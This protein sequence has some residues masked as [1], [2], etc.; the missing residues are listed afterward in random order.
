VPD[1]EP[2]ISV[3]I[4]CYEAAETVG[5][6][7]ESALAQST[8]PHEVIVCDD[9]STDE[10]EGSLAPLRDRIRLLRKENG[11]GASA[12]N[13]AAEAATGDFIA[14]LDADDRYEPGRLEALTALAVERPDLE[15]L[16]TDAWLEQEAVR[17]GRYSDINPFPAGDQRAAIFD[18]CF[19][20]GWPA[21]RRRTLLDAGGFDESY[22]IAYDWECW[23]RLIHR[24][25]RVGLVA[26]ALM[27]YRIRGGSL[28]ADTVA[29]LRERLR[30]FEAATHWQLMPHER[31]VLDASIARDRR[32]LAYEELA[33]A[34]KRGSRRDLFKLAFRAH[35][36]LRARATA[37]RAGLRRP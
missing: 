14:I 35:V 20:G 13:R 1:S 15:L 4:P 18:T 6:A 17:I 22:R 23:A 2:T 11:G 31:R 36:P 9:G 30:L 25:A 21:V 26:E 12:L 32:R 33:A 27:T 37:V 19:P 5:E 16:M 3:V 24:G 8:P 34:A 28:S 10:P 29:S 7:V